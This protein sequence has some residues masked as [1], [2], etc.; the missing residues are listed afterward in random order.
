MDWKP[1]NSYIMYGAGV[2][3]SVVTLLY[4]GSSFI[5][6]LSPVTK[7]ILLAVLTGLLFLASVSVSRKLIDT[8]FYI[9]SAVSYLVFLG[10]TLLKFQPGQ[11]VVLLSLAVSSVLFIAAGY[12]VSERGIEVSS[13]RARKL[14]S[15]LGLIAILVLAFDVTGA[16]PE[17]RLDLDES[18]EV[19][20]DSKTKVGELE[21]VNR[22]PLQRDIDLPRYD[23]CLYTPEKRPLYVS[24]E[25]PPE[26]VAAGNSVSRL[27]IEVREI[28]R[29]E[30][31][32]SVNGSYRVEQAEDCPDASDERKMVLVKEESRD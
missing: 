32:T 26:D 14:A 24:V 15:G 19:S 1:D 5:F 21:V 4:F 2:L 12:L 8:V 30:G 31:E 16:Q 7:S 25:R 10:Y 29:M 20:M 6:R 22:F 27:A 11:G 3:M 23:G 9:L 18:V 28:R 17:Y 13:G